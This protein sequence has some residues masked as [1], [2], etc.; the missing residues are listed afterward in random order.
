[1]IRLWLTSLSLCGLSLMSCNSVNLD[2][3]EAA[4]LTNPSPA[5]YAEI[6]EAVSA[7]LGGRAVTIATDTLQSTSRLVIDPSIMTGRDSA[8][9]DHFQL[10]IDKTRCFIVH[11]QSGQITELKKASCKPINA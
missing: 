6:T 7:M 5:V 3:T 2:N 8:K 4:V 10:M 11:E 1:M 9:P